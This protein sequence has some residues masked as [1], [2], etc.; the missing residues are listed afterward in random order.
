MKE[1]KSGNSLS[2]L[3]FQLRTR[4]CLRRAG[5][6]TIPQ[7]VAMSQMELLM[8]PNFGQ[9]SLDDVIGVLDELGLRLGMSMSEDLDEGRD[10]NIQF[11]TGSLDALPPL[12][13]LDLQI[14][15]RNCLRHAGIETIPQLVAMSQ[16]DLLMLPNFGQTSL[17][18]LEGAL[19][20]HGLRLGMTPGELNR[21]SE[22]DKCLAVFESLCEV[23]AWATS[24]FNLTTFDEL[25][26]IVPSETDFYELVKCPKT[27]AKMIF[28]LTIGDLRDIF[29]S[30]VIL[31]SIR[32]KEEQ[33]VVDIDPTHRGSDESEMDLLTEEP[34]VPGLLLSSIGES[35]R[36]ETYIAE[37]LSSDK[38]N[39]LPEFLTDFIS[40]LE[41]ACVDE[42]RGKIHLSPLGDLFSSSINHEPQLHLL[43]KILSLIRLEDLSRFSRRE[44]QSLEKIFEPFLQNVPSIFLSRFFSFTGKAPSY[45]AIGGELGVTP[46]AARRRHKRLENSFRNEICTDP[47]VEHYC[48]IA[49]SDV[50]NA[51][52]VTDLEQS[53]IVDVETNMGLCLLKVV[54]NKRDEEGLAP[55]YKKEI[56]GEEWLISEDFGKNFVFSLFEG[57]LQ[58]AEDNFVR[59][60]DLN[61]AIYFF[62]GEASRDEPSLIENLVVSNKNLRIRS[63]K[64][65]DWSGNK[66]D[67]AVVVLAMH[68]EPM[69]RDEL[70]AAVDPD[71]KSR[72]NTVTVFQQDDRIMVVA[73]QIYALAEWGLEPY[74]GIYPE[75][76]R[77]IDDNAG[78]VSKE[79]VYKKLKDFGVSPV[80]VPIY[81]E[82]DAFLVKDGIVSYNP[83][84]YKPKP[85][86]NLPNYCYEDGLAGQ[87]IILEPKHFK[88]HSP[89]V[90]FDVAYAN[91]LRPDDD[92]VVS[93][94]GAS[95]EASVIWRPWNTWRTVDVGRLSDFFADQGCSPGD[96]VR[97]FPTP[98]FV[99][100]RFV[101]K[102]SQ[103]TDSEESSLMQILG[104]LY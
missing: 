38:E 75:I 13:E 30:E 10:S 73:K 64:V 59:E 32:L 91:G 99:R 28:E 57:L 55:L 82:T 77:L 6:Q 62:L 5:I 56:S 12:S 22:L 102:D 45:R 68:G 103:E 74:D 25:F 89:G 93:V 92:L 70:A 17:D 4:N 96:R 3:N 18:D 34:V 61:S 48:N 94:E 36:S 90:S 26:K 11:D 2:S 46:E 60:E 40:S 8:L 79:V 20:H 1:N 21:V 100:I 97:I 51:V 87:E 19:D 84:R 88:G 41:S 44:F 104:E 63:G 81:L 29:Q 39:D 27:Y 83:D 85:V 52:R 7:L 72:K 49:F 9:T 98:A 80:S 16:M 71:P 76:V 58:S 95:F 37:A 14:R 65:Y 23:S 15:T 42:E 24:V 50:G 35:T 53:S 31:N 33:D 78:Q 54:N 86:Q 69:N 67:K 101:S 43:R 66:A 47:L